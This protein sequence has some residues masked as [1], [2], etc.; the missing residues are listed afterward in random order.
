MSKTLLKA[1]KRSLRKLMDLRDSK[2]FQD[3]L[4]HNNKS[5]DLIIAR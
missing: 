4:V 1:L 3:F 2:H 5:E